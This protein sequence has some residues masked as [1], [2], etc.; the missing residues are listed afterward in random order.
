MKYICVYHD[1]PNITEEAKLR[2]SVS[3]IVSEDT[4]VD[5]EIGKMTIPSG[6]YAFARFE[7][8]SSEYEEAWNW[9]YGIWLPTSGY[10]PDDRPCFEMYPPAK[11]G[12]SKAKMTVDICV[13]VKPL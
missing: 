2:T 6:K 10:V 1:D 3:I 5:G 13:P 9:V 8:S 4:E 12:S 11:E 7:L